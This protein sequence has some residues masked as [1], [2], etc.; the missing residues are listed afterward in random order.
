VRQSAG[1]TRK[2]N[3]LESSETTRQTQN[4]FKTKIKLNKLQTSEVC[5]L[6]KRDAGR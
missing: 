4:N 1:K 5:L 3:I 6:T 2:K